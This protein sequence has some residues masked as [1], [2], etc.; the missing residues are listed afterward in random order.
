MFFFAKDCECAFAAQTILVCRCGKAI[1]KSLAIPL[2]ILCR[3]GIRLATATVGRPPSSFS[4]N[5]SAAEIEKRG[6][7]EHGSASGCL[8]GPCLVG[9]EE[10]EGVE[11]VAGEQ[12][13]NGHNQ[14]CFQ[15][16]VV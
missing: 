1:C 6:E 11:H 10:L 7:R 13:K 2:R 15:L 4:R 3:G 9:G 14:D 16:F 5:N 12:S 8:Q